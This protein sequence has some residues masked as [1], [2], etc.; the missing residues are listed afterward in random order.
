M[1]SKTSKPSPAP[2]VGRGYT[3]HNC[4]TGRPLAG[5]AATLFF[6][7]EDGRLKSGTG[8]YFCIDGTR[9]HEGQALTIFPLRNGRYH[10]MVDGKYLADTDEGYSPLASLA[11]QESNDLSACWYM[12]EKGQT[13]PLRIMMIGDSITHGT[14]CD[15]ASVHG[16]GCRKSLSEKLAENAENRF[17]FV[18]SVKE[19][20][21]AC[22]QT[23]LYRHEG[24][25]GWVAE[26]LFAKNTFSRGLVDRLDGWMGKYRPDVVLT[27]VGTNDT[28]FT[29]GK[30][31]KE[32]PWTEEGMASVMASMELYWEKIWS[33]MPHHGAVVL[34]TIPPTTRTQCFEDWIE[35]CNRRLPAVVERWNG[36]GRKAVISHNHTFISESSP[37]KGTCSDMVHLSPV[38]YAAMAQAYYEAFT[39][40]F[41]GTIGR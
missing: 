23:A 10:L 41:P 7:E 32:E 36:M 34:A 27:Q 25:P 18:G 40:L 31:G 19:H 12:T 39:S 3:F 4:D 29:M 37:Q 26:D 2:I 9:N 17:V 11:L 5:F 28:A 38:G 13:P 21:T 1:M 24:H 8:E 15:D 6:L 35:E 16:I 22:D 30:S 14:C 20:I 33:M